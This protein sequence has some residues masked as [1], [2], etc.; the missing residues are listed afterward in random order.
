MASCALRAR[1]ARP[2]AMDAPLFASALS[3][4]A[5]LST[6]ERDAA[7]RL[8]AAWDGPAPDLLLAF[9]SSRHGDAV[10]DLGSRLAAATGA[11]TVLGCTGESII[12]GGREVEQGPALS[13]WAARLPGTSIRPFEATATAT[14][15]G[16]IEFR[17]GPS[18]EDEGRAGLILLADPFSFPMDEYLKVTNRE[19]PGV[20]AVGGMASGGQRPGE[21]RLLTE[22]GAVDGGLVGAVIEGDVEVVSVVSQGCRPIGRPYVVTSCDQHLIRELGGQPALDVLMQMLHEVDEEERE[23]FRHQPFV[24]LATDATKSS[25]ERDDFL[26]RG[27]IG[28]Q[29]QKRAVA[30]AAMVRRGQTVQFLI[31]DASSASDD[32]ELLMSTR[33]GGALSPST[34]PSTLGALLF[35]CN[36]R[37]RHMF[38]VPDHDASCVRSALQADVPLAGFF[39]LGE[40]GPVGRENHLHGFTASVALL[41]RRND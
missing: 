29:P 24:G 5:D 20:P 37:G 28:L 23:L 26:V 1:E 7:D 36:G 16:A 17:G 32:L 9:V 14:T 40:I 35:S 34:D 19:L 21:N 31:R 3:T 15:E 2:H 18:V 8:L 10:D 27:I 41:R 11:G 12:G 6:A 38:D 30:I 22:R 25:F 33:G 4:A 39:A 13:L